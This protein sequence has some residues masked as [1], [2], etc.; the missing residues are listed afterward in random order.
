ME[1]QKKLFDLNY[2]ELKT[3]LNKK[4]GIEEKKLNMRA[5]QVFT[6]VYQK[7]LSDFKNLTTVPIDLREQ[8]NKNIS[9]NNCKITTTHTSSDGTLKF[10]VQLRDGNKVECV[11]IPERTRG[12][13]CISSQVGCSLTCTF[14][15]SGTQ[16]LVKN[17]SP[18]FK[19]LKTKST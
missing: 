19:L 3:F 10:L 17:L 11:Y 2:E 7:G 12:T 16:R 14:C 5:Q 8:L 6:A 13:I 18:W 15:R 9:I 1:I 4:I